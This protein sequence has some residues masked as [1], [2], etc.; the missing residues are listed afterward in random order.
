MAD[1]QKRSEYL[2]LAEAVEE[3]QNQPE[4]SQ[5]T[6]NASILM[7]LHTNYTVVNLAHG[8]TKGD[9]RDN[10][11]CAELCQTSHVTLVSGNNKLTGQ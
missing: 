7:I 5:L 4:T 3:F 6:G 11:K 1:Q 9:L 2:G 10:P 8:A